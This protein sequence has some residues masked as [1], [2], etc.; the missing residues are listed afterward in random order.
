MDNAHE[1]PVDVARGSGENGSVETPGPTR[2]SADIHSLPLILLTVFASVFILDWAQDF[3]IP[4]VLGIILSYALSPW[5][6]GCRHG[7]CRARSGPRCC[8]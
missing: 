2:I 4:L 1:T 8:C 7:M 3:F 6:T 5:S